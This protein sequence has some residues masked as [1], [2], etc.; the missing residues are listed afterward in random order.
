MGTAMPFDEEMTRR[1]VE[2]YAARDVVAQRGATLEFLDPQVGERVLDIGSGP[3]FLAAGIDDP[4][5]V[6]WRSVSSR[7]SVS[8][9]ATS[10][11]SANCMPRAARMMLR[12]RRVPSTKVPISSG[13]KAAF[14][15]ESSYA[16][17]A[18]R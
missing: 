11:Y 8:S 9:R 5:S 10:G 17:N 3:G 12:A 2:V 18:A 7:L 16:V 4:S 14:R 6:G 1:P 15:K 13:V